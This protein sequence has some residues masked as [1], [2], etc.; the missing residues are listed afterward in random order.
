MSNKV[1]TFHK[2][3]SISQALQHEFIIP[4]DI[5][6]ITKIVPF[7][8]DIQ[9]TEDNL[10]LIHFDVVGRSDVIQNP[11]TYIND[12]VKQEYSVLLLNNSTAKEIEECESHALLA[13]RKFNLNQNSKIKITAYAEDG[14]IAQGTGITI[15][16]GF[17]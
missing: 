8:S 11:R 1:I 10:C 6:H 3:F 15:T 14:T 16:L 5:H 2:I 4:Y 12:T 7:S 13:K 17:Y 9:Q